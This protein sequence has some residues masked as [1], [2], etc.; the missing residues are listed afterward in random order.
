MRNAWVLLLATTLAGCESAPIFER[1]EGLFQ[2]DLFAAPSVRISAADVFALSPEMRHYVRVDIAG[3]LH[4]EGPQR[5]LVAALY[6]KNEL[7]LD[8]DAQETRNAAGTFAAKAGN[9]LSLVIMTAAFAKELRMPVRYQKVLVDNSWSRS[10]D[11]YFS[12]G[13][14]NLTLGVARTG[15]SIL[16]FESARMTVDFLGAEDVIGRR[17]VIIKENTVIAMY[18]N[19]RAAEALAQGQ[20][21]DA[22]WWTRAAI[23]QDPG[24]LNSYDTLGVVYLQHGNLPQAER[25]LNRAFEHEPENLQV[26]SN[27]ALVLNSEG[28]VEEANAL[29]RK[30]EQLQPYPPFH[31]FNLGMTAMSNGDY[32]AAKQL[33]SREVERDPYYHEFHFWLAVANLNLGDLDHARRQ[34]ALAM[35]YSPSP[36]LQAVYAAKLDRIRALHP[37]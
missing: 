32:Q 30:L 1:P 9:C 4:S 7:K 23:G 13:H 16:D 3:R 33:F 29:T 36:K 5:G 35:E 22:Y 10:G 21:N 37:E 19:N 24:F 31:F 27:L 12:S 6:D 18:M 26:M 34:L 28:R 11:F 17:L 15:T 8:Y 25:A 14:V 2:D 20:V